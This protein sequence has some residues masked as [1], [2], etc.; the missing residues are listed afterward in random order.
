VEQK[1]IRLKIEPAS[2]TMRNIN[3]VSFKTLA[4]L[5]KLVAYFNKVCN[6][7]EGHAC[8]SLHVILIFYLQ[9]IFN[10]LHENRKIGDTFTS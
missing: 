9:Y 6:K 1:K 10:K 7:P 2:E 3:N 8:D 5:I 4:F